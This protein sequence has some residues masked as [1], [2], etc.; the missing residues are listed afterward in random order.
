[1]AIRASGDIR[2]R[3]AAAQRAI[4]GWIVIARQSPGDTRRERAL[5]VIKSEYWYTGLSVSSTH[6]IHTSTSRGKYEEADP[7][8]GKHSSGFVRDRAWTSSSRLGYGAGARG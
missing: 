7:R 4:G 8:R 1:M 3:R 5:I 2:R 6:L